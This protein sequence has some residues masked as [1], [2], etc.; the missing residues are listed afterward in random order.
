MLSILE[1]LIDNSGL[2]GLVE[3]PGRLAVDLVEV[4]AGVW[5]SIARDSA[6]E[7]GLRIAFEHVFD[8][9]T[10]V[11]IVSLLRPAH[12][13]QG[14]RRRLVLSPCK[15]LDVDTTQGCD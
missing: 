2:G 14:C 5:K 12:D 7:L 13:L 1:D 4:W 11:R 10:S 8:L 9:D 3:L 6:I 15:V